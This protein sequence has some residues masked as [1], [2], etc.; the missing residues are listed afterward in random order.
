MD[1]GLS[2]FERARPRLLGLAY[3]V[4]GSVAEAEDVVQDVWTRWQ[5]TVR[6]PQAFLAT[7]TTRV[8]INVLQS[9]RTRRETYVGPWLPEP[10]DTCADPKHWAPSAARR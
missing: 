7:T 3:R 5:S 6:D 8:A 1:D 2:A 10:V 4:L 9:A